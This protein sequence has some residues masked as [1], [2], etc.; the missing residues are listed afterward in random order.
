MEPD[1]GEMS[2]QKL[3]RTCGIN[4]LET[5]QTTY[6]MD[7]LLQFLLVCLAFAV[8]ELAAVIAG[9]CQTSSA[10]YR[11][12]KD[13]QQ[14]IYKQTENIEWMRSMNNEKRQQLDYTYFQQSG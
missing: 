4:S 10:Q 2:N 11:F 3:S 14:R 9:H 1:Y 13:D 12:L 6:L 5:W 8:V 7:D